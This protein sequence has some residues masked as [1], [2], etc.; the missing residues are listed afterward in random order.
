MEGFG[1]PGLEAMGHGTPVVSS[2]MG[3]LPE[4]Y[5]DAAHYFDPSD[6]TDMARVIDEVIE[7]EQLRHELIAKG[8]E[9]FK[10]YSWLRTAKQ[11]HQI[12]LDA[13]ADTEYS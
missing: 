5:G 6:T 11:T 4:V 12:Y 8:H 3:S 13:L 9:Q 1:L 2:D 7:N 10:K